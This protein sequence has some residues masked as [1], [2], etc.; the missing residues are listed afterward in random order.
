[1]APTDERIVEYEAWRARPPLLVVRGFDEEQALAMD[2]AKREREKSQGRT[3]HKEPRRRL[4]C[5]RSVKK[6]SIPL[7]KNRGRLPSLPA[8]RFKSQATVK[9]RWFIRGQRHL[10][11]S[12]LFTA[13]FSLQTSAALTKV[14]AK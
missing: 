14:P 3:Q 7:R 12:R 11:S 13:E 9:E 5:N 1:V 10:E 6:R 4:L 2:E 8:A